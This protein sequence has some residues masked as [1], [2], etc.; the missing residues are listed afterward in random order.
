VVDGTSSAPATHSIGAR[1]WPRTHALPW[2]PNY[3][4]ILGMSAGL[5]ASTEFLQSK[6]SSPSRCTMVE[7][8]LSMN[9]GEILDPV[10]SLAGPL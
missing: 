1:A 8:L 10:G 9:P 5:G 6:C 3:V 2:A 4:S 7:G